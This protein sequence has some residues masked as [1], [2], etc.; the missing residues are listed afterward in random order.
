MM[1][2]TKNMINRMVSVIA[3]AMMMAAMA[4]MTVMNASG[5]DENETAAMTEALAVMINEAREAEG[6]AP[7]YVVPEIN[8]AAEIRAEESI[9]ERMARG[10]SMAGGIEE[11]IDEEI[12]PYEYALEVFAAGTSSA[13]ETFENWKNSEVHWSA[14]MST[15]STHMGIG[16]VYDEDSHYG[17]YWQVTVIRSNVEFADQYLAG[18]EEAV[19]TE[20]DITGDGYVDAYDYIAITNYLFNNTGKEMTAA[21][22]ETADCFK[23]GIITEADAKV[24]AK[25]IL[26]ECKSLPVIA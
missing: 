13:E 20:G 11:V 24:L 1:K 7:L 15:N 18:A 12:I 2:N 17:Y 23:D 4:A 25:Y 19:I 10:R 22:L 5:A 21:Q 9:C 16:V 6:L 26:G 3:A 14:L 8:E